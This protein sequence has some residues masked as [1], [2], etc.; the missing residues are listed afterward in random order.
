MT[1]AKNT[2]R[3]KQAVAN[4]K[5]IRCFS[6]NNNF[7]GMPLADQSLASELKSNRSRLTV[8]DNGR[9]TIHVHSNLWYEF[10]A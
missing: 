4:A 5:D 3:A 10:Q 8:S 9:Y 6:L 7:S 2:N 1:I